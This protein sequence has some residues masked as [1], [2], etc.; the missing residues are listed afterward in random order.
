[1][2]SSGV[3]I[4]PTIARGLDYY[5]GVIYETRLTD[6]RVSAIGAVMSGG[7]YDDLIGMFA[8]QQMPAVGISLGLDRLLAALKE[9]GLVEQ[10]HHGADV[11]VA[12]FNPSTRVDASSVAAELRTAGV[13]TEVSTVEGKLAKQ[14]KRADKRGCRIVVIVGPDE[15]K[16]DQVVIKDLRGGGQHKVARQDFAA[17]VTD[18]LR[19]K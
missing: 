1:G 14:F 5:T 16:T 9:L 6:P 15:R 2:L 18:I 13:D 12:V 19:H 11:F 4:D 10:A 8:K 17:A 3:V 7:R